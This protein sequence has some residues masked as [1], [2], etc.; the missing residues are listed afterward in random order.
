MPWITLDVALGFVQVVFSGFNAA[1]DHSLGFSF[2]YVN[3]ILYQ[4]FSPGGL[5]G[6]VS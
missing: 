4:K 3:K 2:S 5:R 6:Y 1:P